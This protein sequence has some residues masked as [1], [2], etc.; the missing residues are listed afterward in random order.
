MTIEKLFAILND[1]KWHDLTDLSDQI[2]VQTDKLTEFLQCLSKHGIIAYEDKAH[3][4]KIEPEWQNLLPDET[5]PAVTH[6]HPA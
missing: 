1:G 2:Q 5:A 4:I 6:D 3:R